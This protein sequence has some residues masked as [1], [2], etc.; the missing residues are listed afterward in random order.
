[1]GRKVGR[2]VG[3][4][5]RRTASARD[6]AEALAEAAFDT[7]AFIMEFGESEAV[8]LSA[9]REILDRAFGKPPAAVAVSGDTQL[10]IRWKEASDEN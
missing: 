1:M 7:V 3:A 10:T 2:P 9:A 5:N 8:R 6:Q 4:L